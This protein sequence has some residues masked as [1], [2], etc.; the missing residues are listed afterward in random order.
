M[1]KGKH[2]PIKLNQCPGEAFTLSEPDGP[3]TLQPSRLLSV[4]ATYFCKV[5]ARLFSVPRMQLIQHCKIM[6]KGIEE[7]RENTWAA[8][9]FPTSMV[10]TL[11]KST[12][13]SP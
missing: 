7:A 6:L 10:D 5:R 11:Q 3:L 1:G 4:F 8:L 13:L 12:K 9:H 2:I